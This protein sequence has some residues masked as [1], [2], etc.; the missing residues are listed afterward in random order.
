MQLA[1][2]KLSKTL[3][4]STSDGVRKVR[5]T[6]L[7]KT[8]LIF[9]DKKNHNINYCTNVLTY[10]H[11]YLY[12][13]LKLS[14]KNTTFSRTPTKTPN[15]L[16]KNRTVFIKN[17][18]AVKT[19]TKLKLFYKYNQLKYNLPAKTFFKTT[20][21]RKIINEGGFKKNPRVYKMP[22]L[23][24]DYLHA[25]SPNVVGGLNSHPYRSITKPETPQTFDNSNPNPYNA[26]FTKIL[27]ARFSF[28]A[29]KISTTP[30][31]SSKTF[32]SAEEYSNTLYRNKP[33][34]LQ[35]TTQLNSKP[36]IKLT[37]QLINPNQLTCH[38]LLGF[39]YLNNPS[40]LKYKYMVGSGNTN[41]ITRSVDLQYYNFF[42]KSKKNLLK[43]TNILPSKNFNYVFFKKLYTSLNLKKM[44]LNINHTYH[45]TIIR[46]MENL[47]GNKTL[48]QFYPFVNQSIT[49]Y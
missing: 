17:T 26:H 14:Q 12:N 2:Y 34:H 21:R 8:L 10:K 49:K 33:I 45:N 37:T 9:F 24:I 40:Q 20:V 29:G 23:F 18:Q 11:D 13:Y 4:P 36:N 15:A 3:T 19:T 42:S 22:F 27:T 47:S 32:L 35:Y 5:A 38:K 1:F 41:D 43:T 44:H 6:L 16:F 46:F 7:P 48:L 25:T 30:L 31:V 39:F 28:L